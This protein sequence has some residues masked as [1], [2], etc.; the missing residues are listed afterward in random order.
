MARLVVRTLGVFQTELDAQP[1]DRFET[2]KDKAL[3]AYLVV[4]GQ[5]LHRREFLAEMLWP[6]RPEGVARANLRHTLGNLRLLVG[7][8]PHTGKSCPNP[9]VLLVSRDTIQLNPGADIWVDTA[10]FQQFV[11]GKPPLSGTAI[12]QLEKAVDIYRGPFLEDICVSDSTAFQEWLLLKREQLQGLMCNALYRLI[13][14]YELWGIYDRAL[15]YA[16]RLIGL[17]P[18]DEE[19]HQKVMRLLALTGQ[20]GASLNHYESYRL[21]LRDDLGVEPGIELKRLHE[22]IRDGKL[23][24][25]TLAPALAHLSPVLFTPP[26]FLSVGEASSKPPVF[27][28]RERE[29]SRLDRLLEETLEGHGRIA[30]IAGDAGQGKTALMNEFARRAMEAY[31]D[32]LVAGGSCNAISG[33]G[34]P[35]LPFRDWMAM[36]I[37]DVETRWAAGS[38]T[39]EHARRLWRA[40]PLTVQA[41]LAGSGALIDTFIPGELLAYHAAITALERI[42]WMERLEMLVRQRQASK[43]EREQHY[44]F[45]QFTHVLQVL[46]SQHPL[47]LILDDMQWADNASTSLFFHL[48]RRLADQRVLILCAYRP[49]EVTPGGAGERHPLAK[50]LAEFKRTFGDVWVDLGQAELAEGRRFVNALLDSEPNQLGEAFRAT[51]HYHTEGHP[52]FTI[53]LLRAIQQRGD[54]F[55]DENGCWIAGPTLD[56]ELLPARVEAVIGERVDRLDPELRQIAA[57][58][59]VEGQVFTVQVVMEV[60]KT[61]D[62][63]RMDR[64]LNELD[65]RHRLV[66]DLEEVQTSH[67][68]LLRYQ[69]NH[70]LYRDY[71][72]NRLNQAERRLRHREVAA[73]LEKLYASQ[74]DEMAPQLAFHFIQ[75]MDYDSA[76]RYF[77]LA[78]ERAAR[79]YANDEA[80]RH[81]T[82]AIEIA[83]MISSRTVSLADLYGKRGEAYE[84]LGKYEQ[85]RS[86][87]ETAL[88][89]AR[90]AGERNMEW[91]ALIDLGKLWAS[92]DY[93]QSHEY[94]V[95]ALKLARRLDDRMILANSLN[96]IGNWHLNAENPQKAIEYHLEALAIFQGSGDRQNLAN[97]LD[98]LGIASEVGGDS[99][100]SMAY[101]DRAIALFREMDDRLGLVSSLTA[102]GNIGG[103]LRY[104]LT[105][106]SA[107]KPSEGRRNFDEAIRIAREIGSPA[108]EAW[109]LWS[110]GYLSIVQGDF[111]C[112]LQAGQAGLRIA[113]EIGHSEWIVG[114][115]SAL[116]AL[117]LEWFEPELARKQLEQALVL[118]KKLRSRHWIH[119]V[120]GTLVAAHRLL[121]NLTR[122]Q[123][124]LETV[125]TPQTP[126]DTM[127]KRY[128]WARW[129]ELALSLGDSALALEIADR[130]IA[131][132]PGASPGRVISFLWKL[133]GEALA[134]L[135]CTDEAISYLR[136]AIE[137]ARAVG[138]RFLLWR[139]HASLGRLYRNLDQ[140]ASA[141][142]ELSSAGKLIEDLAAT[143]PDKAP[144]DSFL[145]G[146][147]AEVGN[148]PY[149]K[150]APGKERSIPT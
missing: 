101:F 65:K 107:M 87:H 122:A 18:W 60:L 30:F 38:I 8:R 6:D 22:Q 11:Q 111:G 40:Q 67:G 121:G 48:G 104:A 144:R 86:D 36:L 83:A 94:Y 129:A 85:S 59:S 141:E 71:L 131:T 102:R 136:E 35:Y 5:R 137:N 29:L 21:A 62:K 93:D 148:P 149:G 46:A 41:V 89:V 42:D 13:R 44:L 54:L 72:Y 140:P 96:W 7:D 90:Q 12:A 134:A 9:L 113:L 100:R 88:L 70:V 53:E 27:V 114:N 56:W 125:I 120:T 106:A 108:N 10:V 91:R 145:H 64:L 92:R 52:L 49:E 61:T 150:Y 47:L 16:Y 95:Q 24:A 34:D 63:A 58:A 97:T 80:V 147:F 124:L 78:G 127:H 31:P 99:L 43:F 84:A 146:A 75:A 45:D 73:A 115:Q 76:F 50:V 23:E 143:V 77:T 133:K 138:E 117:Y 116:G 135:G 112:A 81:Y 26:S 51:L 142:Q 118:A 109:A 123:T 15:S 2:E 32:L 14:G 37:G 55:K 28:A 79:I 68:R 66:R 126:M 69:F 119:L 98:L 110:L 20:Q 128:C 130:L 103:A 17:A 4:E 139:L 105:H 74:L 19:A 3:L 82:R 57:A 25:P 132:A 39:G 33:V 1:V